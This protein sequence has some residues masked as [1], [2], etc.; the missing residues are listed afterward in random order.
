[1]TIDIKNFKKQLE[2]RMPIIFLVDESGDGAS[3]KERKVTLK[4]SEW[5]FGFGVS[6]ERYRC[7]KS[8]HYAAAFVEY[9]LRHCN[10]NNVRANV[11]VITY[12]ENPDFRYPVLKDNETVYLKPIENVKIEDVRN[13]ILRTAESNSAVL[14]SSLSLCKAIL[15]DDETIPSYSYKPVVIVVS[16]KNPSAGWEEYFDLLTNEGRSANGQFFWVNM[17]AKSK[18]QIKKACLEECKL[19]VGEIRVITR[20][21]E[22]KENEGTFLGQ[23]QL[24]VNLRLSVRKIFSGSIIDA[25]NNATTYEPSKFV[26]EN[27]FN[28]LSK[29]AE[30]NFNSCKSYSVTDALGIQLESW[31]IEDGDIYNKKELDTLFFDDRTQKFNGDEVA[32]KIVDSIKF[33]PYED[34]PKVEAVNFDNPELEGSFGDGIDAMGDGVV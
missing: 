26:K 1:M 7:I 25:F 33:E 34:S 4:K 12:G 30:L 17:G 23:M 19:D 8:A 27:E 6:T 18:P 11:A 9:V 13:I 16:F 21:G 32:K 22:R 5:K 15:E 2:R 28:D 10:K 31:K 3:I 20:E 14:G 24:P 29:K